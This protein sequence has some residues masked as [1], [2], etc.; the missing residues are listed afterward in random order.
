MLRAGR[1]RGTVANEARGG[2]SSDGVGLPVKRIASAALVVALTATLA[3]VA[4]ADR[5]GGVG[6]APAYALMEPQ[7]TSTATS[8]APAPT[9]TV[10][11]KPPAVCPTSTSRPFAPRR[12]TMPG[13]VRR[14]VVVAPPRSNGVPGS[15]SLTSAGKWQ[16]AYDREQRVQPGDRRG[17]VLLNAHVWPDGSAVGNRMLSRLQRGD[18][19]VVIG[20][21]RK[22]CYRV[23][24]RIQVN[25][26]EGLRRYYNRLGRHQLA[27]V[28]CSGKRLGSGVW[29]K[30]TIWYATLRA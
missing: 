29:T 6:A 18:R 21:V 27:I 14:A 1:C 20:K 30:R 16:F 2:V 25:P 23:T 17:N 28:T 9:A 26:S 8:S 19:I 12:I 11:T 10:T 4:V 15:P 7:P 24:E 3:V 22:L 5:L 13:I